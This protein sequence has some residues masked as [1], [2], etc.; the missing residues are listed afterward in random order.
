MKPIL[1]KISSGPAISFSARSD[2]KSYK[3]NN[4]HYHPEFEIIHVKKGAGTLFAG[5]GIHH[6]KSGDL[7]CIGSYLPHY[8]KFDAEYICSPRTKSYIELTQFREDFWGKDFLIIPE[9]QKIANFLEKCKKGLVF[10]GEKPAEAK[11]LL[12]A[13]LEA[14]GTRR[15][16]ILLELLTNL[17]DSKSVYSISSAYHSDN[18]FTQSERLNTIYNYTL[19]HYKSKIYIKEIAE[20][21]NLTENSFCRYFKSSTRKSY[22]QFVT[23]LRIGH[24]C[25]LL[26]E[27]KKSIKEACYESGFNNITNFNRVFKKLKGMQPSE[28]RSSL[29]C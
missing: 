10:R 28:Y 27:G 15:I 5:D 9:N 19:E 7:I 18:L 23:E 2:D 26:S 20:R 17:A 21:T 22:T 29:Q 12:S 11:R 4:W 1:L 6:F 3:H 8:W 16:I 13:L 14:A 24:A 25:K